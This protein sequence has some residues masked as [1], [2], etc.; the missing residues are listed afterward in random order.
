MTTISRA[1]HDTLDDD[2]QPWRVTRG[3][4]AT[5]T[6]VGALVAAAVA[7]RR[8]A[9]ALPAVATHATGFTLAVTAVLTALAAWTIS[10]AWRTGGLVDHAADVLDALLFG[11][12]VA[13]LFTHHTCAAFLIWALRLAH[14]VTTV[15]PAHPI[16]YLAYAWWT[17]IGAYRRGQAH[18]TLDAARHARNLLDD[19]RLD[20]ATAPQLVAVFA[21]DA[22]AIAADAVGDARD[23]YTLDHHTVCSVCGTS[24]KDGPCPEHQPFLHAEHEEGSAS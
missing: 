15:F 19:P 7:A 2:R 1:G 10:V 8:V 23:L 9:L 17:P 14:H 11:L 6:L 20:G 18:A 21:H 22:R 12:S 16:E 24:T 3:V 13:A 4:F 5:V